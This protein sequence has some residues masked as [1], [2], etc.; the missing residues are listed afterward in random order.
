MSV[1]TIK[2]ADVCVQQE[3]L[4]GCPSM[5]LYLGSAEMTG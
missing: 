4:P 3:A 1:S 2:D 5:A